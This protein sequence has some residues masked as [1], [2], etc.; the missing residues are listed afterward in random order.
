MAMASKAPRLK[1]IFDL[2]STVQ[3]QTHKVAPRRGATLWVWAQSAIKVCQFFEL[4][5]NQER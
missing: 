2:A 4:A 5:Q 1:V 3:T